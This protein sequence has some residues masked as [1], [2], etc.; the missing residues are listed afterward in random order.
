MAVRKKGGF[1]LVE[2]MVVVAFIAILTAIAIPTY[3]NFQ[4]KSKEAEARSNLGAIR[5]AFTAYYAE[6]SRYNIGNIGTVV[7]SSGDNTGTPWGSS[8]AANGTKL[9]WDPNT[10]FSVLGFSADSA[11][12]FNYSLTTTDIAYV[13][14]A[15]AD[16]DENGFA[17]HWYITNSATQLNHDGDQF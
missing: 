8:L 11:V 16:L 4:K 5:T 15:S 1:S 9:M 6:E 7:F 12:Y 3:L 13:A 10:V 14:M 2:L 17:S